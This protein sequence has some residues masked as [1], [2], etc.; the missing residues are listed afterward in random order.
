MDMKKYYRILLPFIVVLIVAGE[1]SAQ[2][3]AY[4]DQDSEYEGWNIALMTGFSQFYGDVSQYGFFEKLN[5]ES[6]LSWSLL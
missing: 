2:E 6:K 3:G 5:N 1:I 4:Y